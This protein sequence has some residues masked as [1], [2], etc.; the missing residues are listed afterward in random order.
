LGQYSSLAARLVPAGTAAGYVRV[1][2]TGSSG[3]TALGEVRLRTN[4]STFAGDPASTPSQGS[5]SCPPGRRWWPRLPSTAG[6]VAR[7][8]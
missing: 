1:R 3:L 2:A 6:G 8:L 4:A 7:R 5:W